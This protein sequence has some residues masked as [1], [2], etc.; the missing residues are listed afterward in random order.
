MVEAVEEVSGKFHFKT[1][2]VIDV[3][4]PRRMSKLQTIQ[5]RAGLFV[6]PSF[7][8]AMSPDEL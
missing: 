5:D 3:R 2:S 7:V 1:R 4:F 8:C 6:A